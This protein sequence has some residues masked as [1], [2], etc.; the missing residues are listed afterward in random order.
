MTKLLDDFEVDI[1]DDSPC[2]S[3]HDF[4]GSIRVYVEAFTSDMLLRRVMKASTLSHLSD[5]LRYQTE[6]FQSVLDTQDRESLRPD[7]EM[8]DID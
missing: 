7:Q 1:I 3:P 5:S 2:Q 4:Y 6:R 8:S